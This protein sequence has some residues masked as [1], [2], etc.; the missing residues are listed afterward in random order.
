MCTGTIH[1]IFIGFKCKTNSII[2]SFFDSIP[3][4]VLLECTKNNWCHIATEMKWEFE[5]WSKILRSKNLANK[6]FYIINGIHLNMGI[7]KN[8]PGS[9]FL[10]N[11]NI[12]FV[13]KNLKNTKTGE[14]RQFPANVIPAGLHAYPSL[15]TYHLGG[16]FF[17]AAFGEKA[18]LGSGEKFLQHPK[19]I[20]C[21]CKCLAS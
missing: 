21:R 3:F 4:R 17:Y 6:H 9:G 12:Y 13:K 19:W 15:Y 18:R 7:Q 14:R 8:H 1:T 16:G 11:L 5:S 2:R 20:L 10:K